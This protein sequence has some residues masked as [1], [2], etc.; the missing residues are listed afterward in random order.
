MEELI[1]SDSSFD[2]HS[3]G[4]ASQAKTLLIVKILIDLRCRQ[5]KIPSSEAKDTM[6][7][8]LGR[9]GGTPR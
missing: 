9:L 3:V 4:V 8:Y 7:E 2:I 6:D 1:Y 5:V